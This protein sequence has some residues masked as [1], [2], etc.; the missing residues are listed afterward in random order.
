VHVAEVVSLLHWEASLTASSS[1]PSG[2]PQ[3]A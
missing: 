2:Y 3:P 1:M